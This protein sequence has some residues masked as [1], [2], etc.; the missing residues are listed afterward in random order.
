[1]AAEYVWCSLTSPKKKKKKYLATANQKTWTL[2]TAI[3]CYE[4]VGNKDGYGLMVI[5]LTKTSFRTINVVI[6][7]GGNLKSK[8]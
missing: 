3:A 7:S 8:L 6:S 1:M 5:L 2:T 4:D